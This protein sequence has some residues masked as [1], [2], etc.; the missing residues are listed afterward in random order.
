MVAHYSSPLE[1]N[2][3]E[4]IIS[5]FKQKGFVS[6]ICC[7]IGSVTKS[8]S[9]ESNDWTSYFYHFHLI[10]FLVKL[11]KGF[12]ISAK[13]GLNLRYQQH[14]CKNEISFFKFGVNRMFHL[15]KTPVYWFDLYGRYRNLWTDD[16]NFWYC[17]LELV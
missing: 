14:V 4:R 9:K 5:V 17:Y 7:R 13:Y 3:S 8:C 6:S 16:D 2:S 12:I 10:A 11:D 15:V 1:Y